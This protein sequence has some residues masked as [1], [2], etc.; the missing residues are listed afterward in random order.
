[1]ILL[2]TKNL[3][4]RFPDGRKPFCNVNLKI[5]RGEFILMTGRNGSGKSMLLQHFNGLY[6]PFEGEILLSGKKIHE[7]MP[8]TRRRIGY[9]FQNPDAQIIGDTVFSDILFGLINIGTP[10][11]E[12]SKIAR[13]TMSETGLDD[14][15]DRFPYDLSGGEKRRLA[16]AGVI[17]MDPDIVIFDEPFENLDYE[18]VVKV[19]EIMLNLHG[20]GKTL[21]V[22]THDLEKLAAHSDRIIAM[23][24]G[25]I[26]ID[27]RTEEVCS[28]LHRYGV[29]SFTA[30]DIEKMSW[31]K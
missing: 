2:E 24:K 6:K 4:H 10:K 12:A 18:G 25:S 7:N 23:E 30:G 16:I 11:N 8:E 21:I 15:A 13:E 19:L 17:D 14:F 27:G 5:S 29:R 1:M 22:V 20:K 28:H 9:V 31:L 26:V 3:S